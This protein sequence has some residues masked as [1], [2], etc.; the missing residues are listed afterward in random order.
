MQT[1]SEIKLLLESRGLTPRK[2]LGQNFLIEKSLITKLVDAADVGPGQ[3]VL[4][5]GP[6][7]GT[8]T[9]ALLERGC[10][11]VAVELDRGLAALNRDRLA[12]AHAG[13][14]TLIEGD[15]LEG[16]GGRRLNTAARA[17]LA[18]HPFRLVANLPYAAATPLML[19]LLMDHPECDLLAVTIQKEVVDRLEAPESTKEYGTL[20]I[21]AQALATVEP[22]AVAPRECFWPRPDVTSAL[23]RLVRRPTPRTPD[24][25]GLAVFCQTL[26][27]KRRKQLGA[28]LGRDFP[29]PPGIA[30]AARPETVPVAGM[31][32]LHRLAAARGVGS[33]A[34]SDGEDAGEDPNTDHK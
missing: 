32:E 15:C 10:R 11:V 30:P 24:P 3:L 1:L 6:G 2:S 7:T 18:G 4:E 19:T 20:G 23:V 12:H 13:R 16:A 22:V 33:P 25:A 5:V 8:L 31:I 9:E 28:I 34:P 17:A 21:V 26:F 29:F 14:F 27:S